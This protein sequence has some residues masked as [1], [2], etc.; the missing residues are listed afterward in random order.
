M[1]LLI[2][3]TWRWWSAAIATFSLGTGLGP[4][5]D[6]GPYEAPIFDIVRD[7][8][9]WTTWAAAWLVV[10]CLAAV[11]AI[12]RRAWAWR[13]ATLGAVAIAATWVVGISYSHW[14]EGNPISPTGLALW[15]FFLTANLIAV[16]NPDQFDGVA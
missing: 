14:V 6:E 15:G 8:A 12:T 11:S 5:W 3:P 9:G 1:S 2:R 4:L 16:L 13:T 10:A 7:I